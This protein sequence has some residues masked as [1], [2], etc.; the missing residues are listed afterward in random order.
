MITLINFAD[1]NFKKKQKW[2]CFSAK[3]LGKVHKIIE[4]SPKD[5]DSDFY[6]QNKKILDTKRGGGH[7]LWKP[8]FILKALKDIKE[9]EY[10]IYCDSGAII[11][12][13]LKILTKALEQS[14]QSIMLFELPLLECQWT[15]KTVFEHFDNFTNELV[16]S[17]QIMGGFVVLKKNKVSVAFI[18]KWL[19]L[20]CDEKLLII[21]KNEET[22]FF[23]AHREDQ[24]ILS[25][26]A[27]T[28]GIKPFSDPTD[29]GRFPNQYLVQD[30]LFNLNTKESDLVIDKPIFLLARKVNFFLYL[31]NFFI[32]SILK[33]LGLNKTSF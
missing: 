26:L 19:S 2:N 25:V 15:Q 22:A 30:R 4:F 9:N 5:I 24:S 3:W 18:E 11:L 14:N 17:N 28:E 32:K 10:L 21:Q 16:F 20:C 23:K 12:R 33:V 31:I 13:D 29:Y 7:W 8:Y 27:K 6:N 1:L